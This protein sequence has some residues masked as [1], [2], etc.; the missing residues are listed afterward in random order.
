M[1]AKELG[2]YMVNCCLEKD[3]PIDLS[4]LQKLL[5]LAQKKCIHEYNTPMFNADFVAW[6]CGP[7]LTEVYCNLR[8]GFMSFSQKY[9]DAI[10]PLSRDKQIINDI[11]EQYGHKTTNDLIKITTQEKAWIDIY[12]NGKGV[13]KVIPKSMI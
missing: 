1:L 13:E 4:K 8:E 7:A 3:L 10:I 5:Y 9:P 12:D 2:K 6:R 11:L